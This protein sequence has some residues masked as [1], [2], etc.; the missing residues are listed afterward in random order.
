[1]TYTTLDAL[2]ER[3]GRDLLLQ[4]T[5]RAEVPSGV[6][7]PDVVARAI[8]GAAA[9]IDAGLA[10]RYR[11]PLAAVPAVVEDLAQ[12]IAIYKLHRFEPN[13]KIKDEYDAAV[14]DLRDIASGAKKLDL[15]GIEPAGTG[16]G[17]V[18]AIDR[19]R[20]MTPENLRGFI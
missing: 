14:R 17:G 7:D 1:M 15:A 18:V 5:D 20:P 9:T 6:V 8:A 3:Y 19:E 11:L 13:A 4:V 12:A 16:A 2:I 10:V